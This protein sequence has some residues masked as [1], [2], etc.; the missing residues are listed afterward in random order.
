MAHTNHIRAKVHLKEHEYRKLRDEFPDRAETLDKIAEP[1]GKVKVIFLQNLTPDIK[2]KL[3]AGLTDRLYQLAYNIE[4]ERFLSYYIQLNEILS[5]PK[6]RVNRILEIGPGIGI[7]ENML[8]GYDY[9]LLTL[10]VDTYKEPDL[11]ASILN[12]PLKENSVD[13]VCAFEVLQHLPHKYFKPALEQMR[14]A[15]RHYVYIS[16]PCPS[17][18]FAD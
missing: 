14:A 11:Q 12:M 10:D 6:S 3:G 8:K 16:L 18:P 7:L 15:A 13:L 1:F 9:T 17:K 4:K 5:L 2:Q